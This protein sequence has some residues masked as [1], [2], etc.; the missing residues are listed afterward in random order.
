MTYVPNGNWHGSDEFKLRVMTTIT[1]FSD[2]IGNRYID[3]PG[4]IVQDPPN[5]FESKK[6]KTGGG[7]F[8][9]GMLIA[10]LGLVGL[11]RFKK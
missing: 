11:R 10:L 8:G 1:R 3:I 9:Y 4:K 6:V 7:S 5:D 2:S